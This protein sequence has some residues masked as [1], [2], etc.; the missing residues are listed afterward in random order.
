M[1]VSIIRIN[2]KQSFCFKFYKAGFNLWNI[3]IDILILILRAR[4]VSNIY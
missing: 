2:K 1:V 4:I 3:D